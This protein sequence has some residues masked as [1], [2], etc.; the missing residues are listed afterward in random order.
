[1]GQK[2]RGR[3]NRTYLPLRVDARQL[4]QL[5]KNGVAGGV[6]LPFSHPGFQDLEGIERR[7]FKLVL[8]PQ[9]AHADGHAVRLPPSEPREGRQVGEPG[10]APSGGAH[11]HGKILLNL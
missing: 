9:H 1:M 5:L 3:V 10:R 4:E 7:Q 6:F 2:W 11:G 8:R